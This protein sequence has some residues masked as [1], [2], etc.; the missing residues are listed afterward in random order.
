MTKPYGPSALIQSVLNCDDAT[1]QE[2]QRVLG[3]V[4]G[5]EPTRAFLARAWHLST[6]T[7]TLKGTRDDF[8]INE[9][10]RQAG[11]FLVACA[12]TGMAL[13]TYHAPENGGKEDET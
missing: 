3:R 1:A 13:T 7:R 6:T 4:M 9:G 11:L 2:V 8:L 12:Q 10:K 5:H